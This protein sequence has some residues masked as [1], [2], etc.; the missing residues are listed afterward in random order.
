MSVQREKDSKLR[1]GKA[2]SQEEPIGIRGIS[3]VFHATPEMTIK[4]RNLGS[5]KHVMLSAGCND[6]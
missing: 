1:F 6:K 2:E 4:M 5:P 3:D